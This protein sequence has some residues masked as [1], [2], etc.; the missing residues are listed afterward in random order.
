MTN[1]DA[2]KKA[3]ALAAVE[4]IQPN[5]IVGLGTGSTVFFALE[6]IY[7]R[8]WNFDFMMYVQY[9]KD[10]YTAFIMNLS[11]WNEFNKLNS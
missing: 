7:H 1:I 5:M 8:A 9:L 4:Y 2:G 6:N 3:A 10:F 11:R